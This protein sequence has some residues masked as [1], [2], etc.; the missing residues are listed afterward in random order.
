MNLLAE[1]ELKNLR[2]GPQVYGELLQGCVYQRA[3][4]TGQQIHAQIVKN[5]YFFAKNEFFFFFLKYDRNSN[6][7]SHTRIF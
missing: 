1:M 6:L 7:N 2:V 5:G 4:F 3:F